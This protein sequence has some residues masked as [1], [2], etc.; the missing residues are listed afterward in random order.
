M[1]RLVSL[2]DLIPSPQDRVSVYWAR[3][4][5]WA[6][7]KDVVAHGPGVRVAE[8]VYGTTVRYAPSYPWDHPF[9]GTVFRGSITIR[10]GTVD[11]E[12]PTLDGVYLDGYDAEGH[13]VGEPLLT[14]ADGDGPGP[15]GRST[16]CLRMLWDVER[17]LARVGEPDW[18]TVAHVPD[19]DAARAE[20]GPGVALEPLL[21]LYWRE[22]RVDRYR[23]SV[24][25]NLVHSYLPGDESGSPGRHFFSAV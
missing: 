18:L 7:Q 20:L 19:L 11:G 15:D 17:R 21:I 25:H 16:V 10:P 3:L 24:H 9:R 4:V 1:A 13:E 2:R 6:K 14:L 12:M 5:Q 23:Q 22:G 8:G